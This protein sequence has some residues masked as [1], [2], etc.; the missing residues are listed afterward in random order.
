M[1]LYFLI[2]CMLYYCEVHH[3]WEI[4]IASQS[5]ILDKDHCVSLRAIPQEKVNNLTLHP[6]IGK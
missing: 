5:E 3:L 1:L 2:N 4:T 6:I